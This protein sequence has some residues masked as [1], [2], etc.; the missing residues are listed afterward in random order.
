M[1]L[2]GV[3]CNLDKGKKY[4]KKIDVY[5]FGLM[6]YEILML[7]CP[8]GEGVS[9]MQ[10]LKVLMGGGRPQVPNTIRPEIRKI[11]TQSL[12]IFTQR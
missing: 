6:L 3:S 11:I 4:T 1:D 12:T 7:K 9:A 5:S 8:F 2:H 10:H